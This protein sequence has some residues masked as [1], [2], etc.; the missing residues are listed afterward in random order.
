[1]LSDF[2][3]EKVDAMSPDD[4]TSD[5]SP[6][7]AGVPGTADD[8]SNEYGEDASSIGGPPQGELWRRQ[9][10]LIEEDEKEGLKLDGFPDEEI[11][12][13]LDAMGDDAE[14]PLDDAPNGTSA[15]GLWGTPDHGGFPPRSD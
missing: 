2:A 6:D 10:P 7:T 8:V 11:P 5:P 15:T 9:K 13:I 4:Y 1:M 14:D 3:D 12:E